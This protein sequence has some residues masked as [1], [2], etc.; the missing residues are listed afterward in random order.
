MHVSEATNSV[1]TFSCSWMQSAAVGL[2]ITPRSLFSL[3]K[4]GFQ[5]LMAVPPPWAPEGDTHHPDQKPPLPDPLLG[6]PWH[7]PLYCPPVTSAAL[8]DWDKKYL[9]KSKKYFLFSLTTAH[10]VHARVLLYMGRSN[11]KSLQSKHSRNTTVQSWA[12]QTHILLLQTWLNVSEPFRL[13]PQLEVLMA[14]AFSIQQPRG[15]ATA[16]DMVLCTSSSPPCKCRAKK[17]LVKKINSF[18]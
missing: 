6:L 9:S 17:G 4:T 12:W 3:R 7:T 14:D 11:R 15:Q 13:L 18:I 10:V 1:D 2:C 16:P 5:V 8:T